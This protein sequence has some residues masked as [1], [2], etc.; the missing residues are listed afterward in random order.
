MDRAEDATRH[1]RR[2]ADC[3]WCGAE[4]PNIV[5]LLAHVDDHHLAGEI[6]AAAA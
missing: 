6:D 1:R 5:A 2:T 4:F 3:A